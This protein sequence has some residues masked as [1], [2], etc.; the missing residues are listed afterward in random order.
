MAWALGTLAIGQSGLSTG[1]IFMVEWIFTPLCV[2]ALE[3]SLAL[4]WLIR[5][6]FHMF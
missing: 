5:N 6:I 4:L 1:V 3:K 2:P